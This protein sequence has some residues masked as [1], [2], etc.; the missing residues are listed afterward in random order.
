MGGGKT[1]MSC[2]CRT[3]NINHTKTQFGFSK[4]LIYN[5]KQMQHVRELC[6][7]NNADFVL[8]FITAI[9]ALIKE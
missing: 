1:E 3:L 5:L 8:D 7:R 4:T 2:C 9:V 6:F